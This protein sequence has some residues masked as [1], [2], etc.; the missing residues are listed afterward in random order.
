MKDYNHIDCHNSAENYQI[1][2]AEHPHRFGKIF[3]EPGI[4]ERNPKL[5][6]CCEI[7]GYVEVIGIIVQNPQ[8]T[9]PFY[10]RPSKISPVVKRQLFSLGA[11]AACIGFAAYGIHFISDTFCRPC[12][13]SPGTSSRDEAKSAFQNDSR[14]HWNYETLAEATYIKETEPNKLHIE[15]TAHTWNTIETF[16]SLEFETEIATV[17]AAHETENLPG[18]FIDD[19]PTAETD[20]ESPSSPATI[21]FMDTEV[22]WPADMEHSITSITD[23][24]E[25]EGQTAMAGY[26]ANTSETAAFSM[27]TAVTVTAS[28]DYSW[29]TGE[30]LNGKDIIRLIESGAPVEIIT[31]SGKKLCA[32]CSVKGA[33]PL[34]DRSQIRETDLYTANVTVID[35][36]QVIVLNIFDKFILE[37]EDTQKR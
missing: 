3:T 30:L 17:E 13:K 1:E 18:I 37:K 34:S 21:G 32:N 20:K 5:V 28:E 25:T 10:D 29:L 36:Q 6:R 26:P 31:N 35:H 14:K 23:A 2:N 19:N 9:K 33:S 16:L 11:A 7:C 4:S 22:E 27:D 12:L 24:G 15:E 8:Y